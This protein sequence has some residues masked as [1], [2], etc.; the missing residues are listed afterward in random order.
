MLTS[1]RELINAEYRA[2]EE[3]NAH[4]RLIENLQES[5]Q[6]TKQQPNSKSKDRD[7]F[8][9]EVR[10]NAAQLEKHN[11]EKTHRAALYRLKEALQLF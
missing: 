6:W 5:L 9:I 4:L 10:L 11:L 8:K 7:L 3:F 1:I 2:C